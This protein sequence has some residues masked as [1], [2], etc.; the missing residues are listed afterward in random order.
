[1][2]FNVLQ[3]WRRL[4]AA[5]IVGAACVTP[6]SLAAASEAITITHAQGQTTFTERP[7]KVV[8]FD[9]AVLDILDA[10]KIEPAAVVDA[11]L[12]DHLAN[13]ASGAYPKVGTLFEPNYEAVHAI[14]PDLI[15]V[16]GRSAPKRDDLNRLAP[17]IDLT[18][19]P[20][21]LPGSVVRNTRTL[22]EIYGKQELA[23]AILSQLKDSMH[24][25]QD[26]ASHAG[27]GLIVLTVGGKMTA[28]GPGSRFGVLHD[29]FGIEPATGDLA[30]SNHGQAIS[31]EFVH[32]TDPDWLFVIDRDAAIGR[33][34]MS[35]RR[36]LDNELMHKTTAWQ[37]NQIVYLDA[38]NW[39]LLGSAGLTS[40]QDNIDELSRVL[41]GQQ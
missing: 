20:T 15:I 11:P 4:G 6:V 35:A 14:Q 32:K 33:E 9:P 8:V 41:D 30:T 36:L 29:S 37:K 1:M 38:M 27:N 7:K 40:L 2:K 34:G 12:P 13:Y 16:A 39:Y 17:T 10:L 21:D 28:Y 23:E 25:L 19:D 18:V 3:A 26:K 31:F 5:F 22:A 24:T